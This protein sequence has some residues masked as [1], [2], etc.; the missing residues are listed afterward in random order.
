MK[1]NRQITRPFPQSKI[2]PVLLTTFI[3]IFIVSVMFLWQRP[4]E[5]RP[6]NGAP[7]L[8]T[9]RGDEAVGHLKKSGQ[10]DSLKNAVRAAEERDGRTEAESPTTDAFGLRAKIKASDDQYFHY[11]G[12]SVAISGST[13]VVGAPLHDLRVGAAYVF[14]RSGTAWIE[15]QK[16]TA[17]DGAIRADFGLRVAI[18]G[19]RVI[20][21]APGANIGTAHD[22]GAAYIFVRTGTV[23]NEEIKLTGADSNAGDEFGTSVAISGV[24]AVATSF[25]GAAGNEGSAYVFVKGTIWTQQQK[26]VAA[27]GAN[28]DDLGETGLA[29]NGETIIVGARWC[30]I[31]GSADQGAAYVFTRSGSTWT[32]QQKLTAP[33]GVPFE[34]FGRSVA[35]NGE[36]AIV[37]AWKDSDGVTAGPGSAW[38][39]VRSGNFW[40]PQQKLIAP[41]N[42]SHFGVAVAIDGETAIVGANWEPPNFHGAAYIFVRDG[43]TWTQ[44]QRLAPDDAG[45]HDQFGLGVAMSGE[46]VIVGA[47]FN[48]GGGSAYVYGTRSSTLVAPPEKIA[49]SSNRDGNDEIYV[50]NPDGSG[51]MRLTNNSGSDLHP[52]FTADES[53]ITFSSTRDGNAEIYV[54]NG[55]DG[56]N[57]IRLTDNAASDTQPSFS[58]DGLHIVFTSNRDGND[59]IYIMDVDGRHVT[60]LT[61]NNL[62]DTDP[63]FSPAGTRVLFEKV[64]ADSNRDI[65]IMNVNGSNQTRLTTA[66]G[67]DLSAG[68]SR[69]G[70]R[71]AFASARNGNNEIYVMNPDGTGQTR[72][73]NN[74][75]S[76]IEPSFSPD[77][78]HLA[79]ETDRDGNFEIYSMNLDGTNQSRLTTSSFIDAEPDWGGFISPSTAGRISAGDGL[80]RDFFGT[81]VAISGDT[82]IVGADGVDV[83]PNFLVGAA[84]VFVRIGGAWI[85]EQKLMAPDGADG[86]DFGWS[87]AISGGTAIVGARN[88]DVGTGFDQGSAYVFVRNGTIWTLQQKL[89]AADAANADS[90]GYSVAITGE[91]AMVGAISD[92]IGTNNGQGSAYVFVR[93][94][95]MWSQQ[96]QLTASDG[97]AQDHF[98]TSVAISG[99]TAIVGAIGH[100]ASQGSAYVFVRNGTMWIQQQQLTAADGA[101]LD[102]FGNSVGISG[103]TAIVGSPQHNVGA[104]ADQGSAYIFVRNGTVWTQQQRLTAM[105]GLQNDFLG[106]SVAISGETVIVG[107]NQADV[108][109]ANQGA[110]YTFVRNGTTWTQLQK[111]TAPDAAANDNF[112][113]A[114]GMSG[115]TAIVGALYHM[116]GTNFQQGAAYIFATVLPPPPTPTPS[117]TPAVTPLPNTPAGSNIT[118]ETLD[119]SVTFSTVTQAGNTTFS[120]IDPLSAGTPPAGYDICRTCLAYD[121]ITTAAYTP[122]VTVCLGVPRAVSQPVFLTMS[123]LHGEGGILVDRTTGHIT[124]DGG[125][126]T[127]CGSVSSLS[128]FVLA[129][130][131]TAVPRSRADFDGDGRTDVSVFRPSEGNWYIDRSTGGFT[132]SNWGI[133]TDKLV[134]GDYDGDGKADLAI[135]RADADPAHFDY[136][137]LNSASGTIWGLSWGLPGDIPVVGDYDGDG[138][139]DVT[140]YRPSNNT[141]Y[142]H[143]STAGFIAATFGTAGDIP[144][145]INP[146]DDN[147]SNIAVFRPNSNTWYIATTLIDPSHNFTATPWGEA[148]DILVPADYDGDNKE[149]VAIFRPSEGTWYVRQSSNGTLLAIQWG[150]NGDVPVPGDYDG[151]GKD[152]LAVFRGGNWYI[153]GT[154]SPPAIRFGLATDEPIPKTYIP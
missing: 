7:D 94:G 22:Q 59:E 88:D 77:G 67:D 150:A 1:Y 87:V 117:P 100:N 104:N 98:G 18:D 103:E 31:G 92:R 29:I 49:F 146:D 60:R 83:P 102:A 118:L 27:D 19:E 139:S 24:T 38:I 82:A 28:G 116:V 3:A 120:E 135:F 145:V 33:D 119:A 10:Y 16:L 21:G 124:D 4:A 142:I 52:S 13:A 113:R 50:M 126:R 58:R 5:M 125:N 9:L 97:A 45:T 51:Q 61:N 62:S 133:S 129:M 20:V 147:T 71:I 148:G 138:R 149:D 2:R 64:G 73:T 153:Y 15:Q 96:Q 85:E 8:P 17:S 78:T 93:S 56:S 109:A 84:Y 40:A 132:T 95:T 86:D 110:A 6:A 131:S 130:P 99:E 11:F 136:Y 25:R 101:G 54:M 42:T 151:D 108:T 106:W 43:A 41:D 34:E 55:D 75:F 39:F 141:W 122:P 107:A 127:V 36:T 63:S 91:T 32:Q 112:A 111:I 30:T 72:L 44:Q 12:D 121:I 114:V 90:F 79:F 134:P 57:P 53:L 123:L 35:I 80:A 152:D 144:V 76:D 37:G 105:D 66:A 128:P 23:W 154:I 14:V 143:R 69:D 115:E 26:L 81:S 46:T 137:I 89:T 47:V 68:F 140:V 70:T 74:S 65:Y 48:G